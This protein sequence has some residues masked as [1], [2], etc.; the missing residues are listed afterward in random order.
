MALFGW[1]WNYASGQRSLDFWGES[2]AL[3]IRDATSVELF[4]LRPVPTNLKP[5]EYP[6]VILIQEPSSV[7]PLVGT[8]G[9]R[10]SVYIE[11]NP[12]D[13]TQAP[14]LIHARHSLLVDA[15]FAWTREPVANQ[16]R[17]SYGARFTDSS[18]VV[19]IVFDFP[20]RR[21]YYLEERKIVS[22]SPKTVEGWQ[23]YFRRYFSPAETRAAV[24]KDK[25]E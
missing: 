13:V 8:Q 11:G 24:P 3:T 22:L 9:G 17:W 7:S 5:D 23:T 14:G 4:Q 2:G 12:K 6:P 1:W 18:G 16:A 20:S 10:N 15:G 19:T 25:Q 21:L